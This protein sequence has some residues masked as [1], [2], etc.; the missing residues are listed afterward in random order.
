MR[1]DDETVGGILSRRE[2]VQ[3][4]GAGSAVGVLFGRTGDPLLADSPQPVSTT[5]GCVVK[6]QQTEGPYFLDQQLVRSDI[7]GEPSTGGTKEG[8]P[9]MLALTVY[10]VSNSRC[11]VL[12]GAMV[13]VWQCDAKGVYSGVTDPTFSTVGQKFLRGVQTS[14][15]SGLVRFTTIHPGWYS[16]RAVHIHFKIRTEVAG[17]AWEFTSQWYFD[18]ALN[19]RIFED[20]RYA[21]PGRRDTLNANDGIYRSGGDQLLL[22]PE[23]R[24]DGYEAAFGIGL[25]LSDAATGRPDGGGGRGRG[26]RGGR[27]Q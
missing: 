23:R 3:L 16:G 2:L 14:N 8:V 4:I 21:R 13:D 9:L 18:E 24:G 20:P 6:P 12:E 22:A 10:D 11:R 5:P 1:N 25:D 17:S 19:D 15:A 7:R 27:G 26:G